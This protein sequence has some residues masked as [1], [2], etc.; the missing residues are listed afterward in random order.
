MGDADR[1][2]LTRRHYR[3]WFC[4][5][6]R[7]LR[8]EHFAPLL[9]SNGGAHRHDHFDHLRVFYP[10]RDAEFSQHPTGPDQIRDR[11]WCRADRDHP[12]PDRVLP[13]SR[14]LPR[15][16]VDAGDDDPDRLPDRDSAW[17]RSDL[18]RC[19]HCA[20]ERDRADHAAGWH[21]FVCRP[22]Y[23]QRWRFDQR[24]HPRRLAVCGHDAWLYRVSVVRAGDRAVA[25]TKHVLTP[26]SSM[27]PWS[28]EASGLSRA[29]AAGELSPVEVLSAILDRAD[30]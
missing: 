18:V 1:V 29:Y 20:D 15:S 23:S 10:Q 2:G 21:E 8:R 19:V 25:A 26:D 11:A 17:N 4:A 13:D 5:H 30:R 22:E 3:P 6:G 14:L 7:T 28:L 27:G 16:A 24:R 9:P 12:D